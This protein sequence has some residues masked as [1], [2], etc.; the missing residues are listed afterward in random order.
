MV[1]SFVLAMLNRILLLLLLILPNTAPA[2]II[3]VVGDSLSAAYG[4]PVEKGWVALLAE[5]LDTR[6]YPFRIVNASISGDTT[7][8]ARARLSRALASHAPAVVLLALGGNDG[9]RALSLDAMKDNLAAMIASVREAGAQLLLIGVQLPPNYGPRYTERFQAVYRELAR[10]H[11]T[12][13]LPSL[14]DGIGTE[15]SLMQPDGIHPNAAAQPLIRDRVWETLEPL[16]ERTENIR[17]L[18]NPGQN[19]VS[20]DTETPAP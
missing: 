10:E 1:V 17:A 13:L 7:A 18:A 8:S 15:Q 4:M 6:D 12:A 11:D 9:L 14:V 16:L 2:G 3:L 19:A 20:V 5:R